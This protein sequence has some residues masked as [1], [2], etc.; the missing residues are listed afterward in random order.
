LPE[1][2]ILLRI[3]KNRKMS[4]FRRFAHSLVSGYVLLGANVVY[5]LAC[6]PLALHYLSKEQFGLWALTTQ[7]G[8]YMALVDFGMRG[9]IS[10][11]L[12]DYKDTREDGEYGGLIQTGAL[13]GVV[14]GLLVLIAGTALSTLAGGWLLVAPSLAHDFSWL[15]V[16]QSA[17]LAGSFAT[18][19][20][21]QI[22]AAHQRF[23]ITNYAQA[24]SFLLG[25]GILWLCFASGAGVF[26]LLWSNAAAWL[27]TALCAFGGSVRLGLLPSRGQWGKPTLARFNE[28]FRFGRDMFMYSLGG[29]LVSGSQAILLTRWMGLESAALWSV[30]TR[31]Y[32]LLAQIIYRIFDYSTSALAEM[33][34]RNERER[35]FVRFRG[36]ASLSVNFSVVF[37][38]LFVACNGPFV[39][40]WTSGKMAWSP[41][42]DWIL[43]GW[44]VACVIV[45]AHTG[46]VG[47]TK[48]FRFLRWVYFIEGVAFIGLAA[49][50]TR[51]WGI[52][53]LLTASLLATMTFT[54]PYSLFRTR[55]YF[56]MR[57]SELAMWHLGAIRLAAWLVP[58]TAFVSWI[59]R[60]M[61]A[62]SRF[63]VNAGLLGAFGL[64]LLL[65]LGMET[66]LPAEVER[67]APKWAQ[68]LLR[69]PV[70]GAIRESRK[71]AQSGTGKV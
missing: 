9:S 47:Q 32:S 1:N 21:R 48:V 71:P 16:G 62:L 31:T 7:L 70:F 53:G 24:L 49:P 18:D 17:L 28:L 61:P 69:F 55:Q 29:Q 52:T 60:G 34:V 50:L 54:L 4:R 63:T 25:L 6:I 23:D 11:I 20:L 30:C 38:A 37:G 65:R 40:L 8:G 35:L 66:G 2:T 41:V 67:H 43:A 44:L 33:I 56:H 13:V 27:L 42:N 14:Q 51:L 46:F 59:A 19:V 36:I 22:L 58:A 26:S 15:M 45:H 12:V 3:L 10:R 57:W 39:R 68:R 5:T 64:W